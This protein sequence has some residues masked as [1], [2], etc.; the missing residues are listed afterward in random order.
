METNSK[1]NRMGLRGV[2]SRS[3]E[4]KGNNGNNLKRIQLNDQR[5]IRF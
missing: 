4:I 1:V 3:I 5:L 2:G